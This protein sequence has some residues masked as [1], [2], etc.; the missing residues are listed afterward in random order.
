[1][2]DLLIVLALFPMAM[3]A[4]VSPF[5]GVV[6]WIWTA[7]LVP[8]SFLFSFAQGIRFNLTIAIVTLLAW[9]I[10]KEPKRIPLNATN[11]L[12]ILFLLWATVSTVTGVAPNNSSFHALEK[13]AK[14]MVLALVVSGL[15]NTRTRVHALLFGILLGMGYHGVAEGAKFILSGGSHRVSGPG[16][17]IISDNNHFALAMVMILPLIAYLYYYSAQR[18]VRLGLAVALGLTF[19]SVIGTFS[20]GGLI[21]LSGVVLYA[22]IRTNHK[23]TAAAMVALGVG[24]VFHFAP[25]NWFERMDT[26]LE[27]DTDSSFMGRVI[28][29]KISILLAFEHPVFGG[30]LQA[31]QNNHIWQQYSFQFGKLSFIPTPDIDPLKSKAAHS[32]YFQLLGDLG[33]AGL[34]L[35][36]LIIARTWYITGRM[37]RLAARLPDMRWARDLGRAFQVSLVAYVIAGAA[38]NMAYFELIYMYVALL[39]VL[40][41]IVEAR[42]KEVAGEKHPESQMAGQRFLKVQ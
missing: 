24:F 2:R 30:G 5:T 33:F 6:L 20:R 8:N 36:L 37:M 21:A 14:I 7:M 25:E 3:A 38:L 9:A 16:S 27:A 10:S 29:W 26:I 34:A 18:I 31:I 15:I 22:L 35:F 19:V 28:A 42:A 13:L 39:A 23:F 12:L 32:V 1:M 4:F 41:G 40:H 17:S 11:V